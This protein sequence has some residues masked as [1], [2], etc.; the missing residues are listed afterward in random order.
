MKLRNFANMIQSENEIHHSESNPF[1]LYILVCG[2][3]SELNST[4]PCGTYHL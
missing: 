2:T 3:I 4:L 1:T